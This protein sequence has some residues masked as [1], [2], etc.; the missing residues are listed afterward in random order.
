MTSRSN[1]ILAVFTVIV[2]LCHDDRASAMTERTVNNVGGNPLALL[3][4]RFL[5]LWLRALGCNSCWTHSGFSCQPRTKPTFLTCIRRSFQIRYTWCQ[6]ALKG[7]CWTMHRTNW[8]RRT[9]RFCRTPWLTCRRRMMS[10]HGY[11]H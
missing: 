11:K 3:Q 10:Q 1:I 2:M 6:L 8:S 9:L 7:R 5:S 4:Y